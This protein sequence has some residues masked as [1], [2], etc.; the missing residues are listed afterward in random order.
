MLILLIQAFDTDKKGG[1]RAKTN[2]KNLFE[3]IFHKHGELDVR[4]MERSY[5]QLGDLVVDWEHDQLHHT[6]EDHCLKFDHLD[7]III[8]G[9]LQVLPWEPQ[10]MQLVSLV[11]MAKFT[12]KPVLG[13]GFGA[14]AT[15]YSLATKGA[16]FNILNGPGGEIIDKLSRFQRYSVG[17]GAFPSGWLDKETGDVYTFH[18]KDMAWH[19]VCNLGIHSIDLKDESILDN[20][21]TLP[22]TFVLKEDFKTIAPSQQMTIT[23]KSDGSVLH[24][25]PKLLQHPYLRNLPTVQNSFNIKVF[26]EWR[27]NRDGSLP[28]GENLLVLAE[29][30]TGPLIIARDRILVMAMRYDHGPETENPN[31][32][33]IISNFIGGFLEA[34]RNAPTG[35]IE[36]SLYDFLFGDINRDGEYDT[37]HHRQSMAPPL[38][39]HPIPTKWNLPNGP[40]KT[41]PPVMDMFFRSPKTALDFD[42]TVLIAK[43]RSSNVGKK[44]KQAIQN[45]TAARQK[46]LEAALAKI[47]YL[48]QHRAIE[49]AMADAKKAD[50]Y[51]LS[52][53]ETNRDMLAGIVMN[54]SSITSRRHRNVQYQQFYESIFPRGPPLPL[55]NRF[56]NTASA[57]S[58]SL[59]SSSPPAG[60]NQ[61]MAGISLLSEASATRV[62]FSGQPVIRQR[63]PSPFL[64]K[65][66]EDLV[67][68]HDEGGGLGRDSAATGYDDDDEFDG[69]DGRNRRPFRVQYEELPSELRGYSQAFIDAHRGSL[70]VPNSRSNPLG[71]GSIVSWPQAQTESS[72]ARHKVPT[73]ANWVDV[74][75]ISGAGNPLLQQPTS[76]TVPNS[77]RSCASPSSRKAT[78]G[79]VSPRP[80]MAAT[81]PATARSSNTA[82]G[83]AQ[84]R[85]HRP[86]ETP[87][88]SPRTAE[89]I[90]TAKVQ[91]FLPTS[92]PASIR[93]GFVEE[94]VVQ[95]RQSLQHSSM[96]SSAVSSSTSAASAMVSSA[97]GSPHKGMLAGS[98][99]SSSLSVPY[100]AAS[101]RGTPSKPPYAGR[102]AYRDSRHMAHQQQQELFHKHH[103]LYHSLDSYDDDSDEEEIDPDQVVD[104]V[105]QLVPQSAPPP[106]SAIPFYQPPETDQDKEF[107]A[108]HLP[109]VLRLTSR[110]RSLSPGQRAQTATQA[111]KADGNAATRALYH[112]PYSNYR[113]IAKKNERLDT[114]RQQTY[115]GTYVTG[116]YRSE[117]EQ[118]RREQMENKTK[119][120]AGEFQTRFSQEST[121]MP[122]RQEGQVR[123]H[124]P[125]PDPPDFAVPPQTK[126]YDWIYMK[127]LHLKDELLAGQWK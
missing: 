103:P 24:F 16:R 90:L 30:K 70:L 79:S 53:P 33:T 10:A 111:Q 125:Y 124:G 35:K 123:P 7:M 68:E 106:A 112:K 67:T 85:Q 109:G 65:G 27:L 126:A 97:K 2:M 72:T 25:T 101:L 4:F 93:V 61:A 86:A 21:Q 31:I 15:V 42:F 45:P 36:K 11:H 77:A 118:H 92:H 17:T 60:G 40:I 78:A 56:V 87:S 18:K 89:G 19:P 116:E 13:I 41:D 83:T 115:E 46:R 69:S 9:D 102:S 63:S 58:S 127:D 44:P 91:S 43:R 117:E 49:K 14:F 76:D 32:V 34:F 120:L 119:F 55:E 84:H 81:P 5:D 6:A 71:A 54:E 107:R 99:M 57:F 3:S 1:L 66:S 51:G 22:K 52:M 29:G 104:G 110:E 122:L 37:A 73:I 47:G 62:P 108:H 80:A 98:S 96:M 75:K 39:R 64:G 38:A 95:P 113:R 59:S 8:D 105:V 88:C 82:R 26:H 48:D 121:A 50:P 12:N 114:A 74:Y 23:K 94:H 28:P 100:N 20:E